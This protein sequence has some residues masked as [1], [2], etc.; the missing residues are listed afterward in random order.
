MVLSDPV[1]L[2]GW[3]LYGVTFSFG[4]EEILTNEETGVL[5]TGKNKNGG[6]SGGSMAN[7]NSRS[8]P[9]FRMRNGA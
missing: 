6:R 7:K 9:I 3:C 8:A 5:E 4:K 1:V 2:W